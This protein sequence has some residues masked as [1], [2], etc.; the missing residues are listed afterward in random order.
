MAQHVA[1]SASQHGAANAVPIAACSSSMSREEAVAR[2]D[3]ASLKRVAIDEQAD[4]VVAALGRCLVDGDAR[5]PENRSQPRDS[6]FLH[7]VGTDWP[8]PSEL[9]PEPY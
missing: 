1:W 6:G 8:A 7:R 3:L 4:A 2:L 5:S 9:R